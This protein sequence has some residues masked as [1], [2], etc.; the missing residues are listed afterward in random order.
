MRKL[1]VESARIAGYRSLTVREFHAR[2]GYRQLLYR[3][4]RHPLILL[5]AGP[6]YLFLVRHRLPI[7]LMRAGRIYWVSAMA[8]NV[9]T[10]LLLAALIDNFGVG[11]VVM[12]LLPVLLIAASIGVWLFYIQHQFEEAHWDKRADWSFHDAAMRGSSHLE[13]PS[14]LRWFTASIGVH[15]VHHLS[16]RIPF[17]RLPEVLR[18]Y[19]RLAAMNRIT[20]LQTLG[21]LRLALWDEDHRRLVS[22]ADSAHGYESNPDISR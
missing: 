3:L 5:G 19:P 12:A 14:V 18:A 2:S 20:A 11:I 10:A 1:V 9:A 21:K 8:T 4:Y 15:H 7:G 17:Y 13:L 16:S 22:F 6:A